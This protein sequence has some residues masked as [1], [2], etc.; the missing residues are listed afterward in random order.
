MAKTIVAPDR[1]EQVH[2]LLSLIRSEYL[3]MPGLCLTAPQVQR[4]WH[5]DRTTCDSVLSQLVEDRFLR[6]SK[7][8]QYL[9]ARL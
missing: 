6:R 7:S 5:L 1:S 8:G 2:R 3:E 9:R 4:L